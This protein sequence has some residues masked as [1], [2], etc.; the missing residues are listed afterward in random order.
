MKPEAWYFLDEKNFKAQ[1][2]LAI[3]PWVGIL[4]IG[5]WCLLNP[6]WIMGG[7]RGHQKAR[8]KNDLTSLVAG[9]DAYYNRYNSLPFLAETRPSKDAIFRS[10][11]DLMGVLAGFNIA[12]MNPKEAVFIT[13]SASKR[14]QREGCLQWYLV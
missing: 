4:A 2:T 11:E 12:E 3:D 10:D 9:V 7:R 1:V 6:P 14:K 8:A 5:Y 13:G